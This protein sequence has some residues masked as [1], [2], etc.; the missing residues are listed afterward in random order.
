MSLPHAFR[1]RT[2]SVPNGARGGVCLPTDLGNT[3]FF[4]IG[5]L[6]AKWVKGSGKT[7]KSFM[8]GKTFQG[9]GAGDGVEVGL[10]AGYLGGGDLGEVGAFGEPKR[11]R[12]LACSTEP[13]SQGASSALPALTRYIAQLAARTRL[14]CGLGGDFPLC[15]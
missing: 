7:E 13:F 11:R 3:L 14:G 1:T 4:G 8:G 6:Q 12:P 2:T 15:V 5:R 10:G 9:V